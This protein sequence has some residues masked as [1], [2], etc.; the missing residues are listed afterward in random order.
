[1]KAVLIGGPIVLLLFLI[2]LWVER[3]HLLL[4]GTWP[5]LKWLGFRRTLTGGLHGLWYGRHITSYLNCLRR[6]AYLFGPETG[7]GRWLVNSY[8]GK[9][10]PPVLAKSI[11]S[12]KE[13]VPLQD[14]GVSV[15]PYARAR[16]IMIHAPPDIVVTQCGC[17][18]LHHEQG[19]SCTLCEPPFM[20]CMLIGR[21]LTDFLLDH[22][23]Q[24]TRRITI[25]EALELL[26]AFHCAG[27]VHA[28]W[29][30]DCIKDR[31]YVICNCCSCCCLGFE[32]ATLGFHQMTPSGYVA[33]V[34][35]SRCTGCG[36]AQSWCPFDAVM[37]RDGP[38]VILREKCMG[39]GVCLSKCPEG[40]RSLRRDES[41]GLP[42]D[43][44]SL[45]RGGTGDATMPDND[46]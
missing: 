46:K 34:D 40:A 44:R 12:I 28:A 14:L 37:I 25:E 13:D 41:R 15:I 42:M 32:M 39:C 21:P 3:W 26:E 22:K 1:M 20:T 6:L 19:R 29:F 7:Y 45:I 30:K 23:P 33:E 31:F 35:L 24:N 11:I 9:V 10:L 18:Q 43:V 5:A 2:W 16:D 27:M 4:P 17:K 36:T 8:H 38:P